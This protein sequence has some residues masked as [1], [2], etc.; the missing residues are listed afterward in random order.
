M[1]V[2]AP[3]LLLLVEDDVEIAHAMI[4]VLND[5][6]FNVHWADNGATGLSALEGGLLPAMIVLDLM[7]PRMDGAEFL[8][9][10]RATASGANLPVL[11][12]SAFETSPPLANAFLRKPFTVDALIAAINALPEAV[13]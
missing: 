11:V 4:D 3:R 6:G 9:R 12:T 8:Q 10:L 1:E 7:M 13:G 2:R 5:S